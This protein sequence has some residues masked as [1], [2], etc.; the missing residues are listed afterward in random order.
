MGLDYH[1]A[2]W[3]VGLGGWSGS[4]VMTIGRQNWWLSKRES[5]KLGINNPPP[6][7]P[8]N[9]SDD[10]WLHLGAHCESVDISAEE[11]PTHVCDLSV[12]GCRI[13]GFDSVVDLGTA[14]HI[15]DQTAYWQNIYNLTKPGG[16]IIGVLPADGMCGHG[17]YQ[18]SPEF[19]ARMGGT[20]PVLIGW[21]VY[22]RLRVRFIPFSQSGRHEKG[23]GR[24]TYVA[25]CI[26]TNGRG[27]SV[28]V[29][30]QDAQT[31]TTPP[32]SGRLVQLAA[33]IPG[34]RILERILR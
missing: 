13:G 28:P 6:Y 20:D 12:P 1:S 18:F 2:K 11:K 3:I 22:G 32:K 21:L 31:P 8:R 19:F 29:Q 7:D 23:F 5:R 14:E 10:F 15:A 9:Y 4:R 33:E 25:F 30:F 24:P 34:I 17:L 27:F 16:R 26:R